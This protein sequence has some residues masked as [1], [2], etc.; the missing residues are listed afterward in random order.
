MSEATY[1]RHGKDDE[2]GTLSQDLNRMVTNLEA[3]QN[4]LRKDAAENAFLARLASATVTDSESVAQLTDQGVSETRELMQVDRVVIYRFQ[5]DG[6]GYI[7]NES[8][9]EG[10][11]PAREREM[12]DPCIPEEI[13]QAF[14]EGRVV[15]TNE[16]L[17][18]Q[19]RYPIHLRNSCKQH[20]T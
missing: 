4:Q 7:A 2:L 14:V 3:T 16:P 6:S 19:R 8:S 1:P 18:V 5:E 15:P 20:K 11:K 17:K 10:V 12:K 9:V 13:R